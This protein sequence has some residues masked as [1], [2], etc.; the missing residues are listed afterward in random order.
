MF[1]TIISH[2]PLEQNFC[3]IFFIPL[4]KIEIYVLVS[5]FANIFIS[6]GLVFIT[7]KNLLLDFY[8]YIYL[9]SLSFVWIFLT[10]ICNIALQFS[11]DY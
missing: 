8:I 11:H 2:Y 4:F 5:L 3:G 7:P 1:E 10:I 6:L 9:F